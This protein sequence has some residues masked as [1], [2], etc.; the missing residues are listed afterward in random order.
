MLAVKVMAEIDFAERLARGADEALRVLKTGQPAAALDAAWM[1]AAQQATPEPAIDNNNAETMAP[2][3]AQAAAP[4]RTAPPEPAAI[5]NNNG[6][7]MAAA[8]ALDEA[9]R[10]SL[11][12]RSESVK[13]RLL[14][15]AA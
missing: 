2:A 14:A 5:D 9:V 3:P 15:Q 1:A 7:T 13:E 10:A 6:I 11:P 8:A 12:P 4:A